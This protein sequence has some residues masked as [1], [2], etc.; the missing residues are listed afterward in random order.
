MNVLSAWK[1]GGIDA[2]RELVRKGLAPA[3]VLAIFAGAGE[4]PSPSDS[5]L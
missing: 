2:V 5:E 4:Q 3:A 1:S